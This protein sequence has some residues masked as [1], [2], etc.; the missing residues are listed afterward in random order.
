MHGTDIWAARDPVHPC[1]FIAYDYCPPVL[2][3]SRDLFSDPTGYW[4]AAVRRHAPVASSFLVRSDTRNLLHRDWVLTNA[5]EH[6]PNG[7]P[8]HIVKKCLP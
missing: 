1:G 3:R 6:S 5:T 2:V 8:Y 7:G 4:A